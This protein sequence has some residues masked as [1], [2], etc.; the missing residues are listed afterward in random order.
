MELPECTAKAILKSKVFLQ[1]EVQI[2]TTIQS[3]HSKKAPD[4]I[5]FKIE[6]KNIKIFIGK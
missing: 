6:F 5:K 3:F 4:E 2:T 1:V